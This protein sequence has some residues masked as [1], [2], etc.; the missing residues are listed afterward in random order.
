MEN[1]HDSHVPGNQKILQVKIPG[2]KFTFNKPGLQIVQ[3]NKQNSK[4]QVDHGP[5]NFSAGNM[6]G[7]NVEHEAL[8]HPCDQNKIY[9]TDNIHVQIL[10]ENL[11]R[12]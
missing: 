9:D 4:I 10:N 8:N 7:E 2:R 11:G 6:N 12:Y 1:R 5:S 3:G